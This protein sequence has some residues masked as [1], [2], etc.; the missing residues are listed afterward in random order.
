MAD[1]TTTLRVMQFN[2]EFGGHGVDFS[3]VSK[4]ILACGADVVAIQ[5]GCA[6][7]PEIAA[8]LGWDYWD[9]RTQ[10]VSNHPLLTPEVVAPGTILVEVE[11]GLVFGVVN[12]H[13]PSRGYGPTR[14]GKGAPTAKVLQR[15]SRVRLPSVEAAL[16][17][18]ETLTKQGI[19]VVL[20]GDF[21]APS[22]RDWTAETVGL[23]THVISPMSWPT[24]RA[25]ESAGLT[26][27]YRAIYPDPVARQGLTW[28][29]DRPFV[30]G[31]NP[32]AAGKSADRIDLM[33]V[34]DGVRPLSIEIVGEARSEFTD[35]SI[36]PWPTDHRALV[37]ELKISLGHAP[38]LVSVDRRRGEVG[39]SRIVRYVS[40]HEEAASVE[41]RI[42]KAGTF[43][44]V[45]SLRLESGNTGVVPW[46][47]DRLVPGTYDLVLVDQENRELARATFWLVAPGES[48]RVATDKPVYSV[49]EAIEASWTNGPG[50]KSDWI[51]IFDRGASPENSK[52]RVWEYID[53]QVEGRFR[54]DAQVRPRRWP[55]PAGEY[56]VYLMQDDSSIKLSQADFTV[57]SIQR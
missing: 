8:D 35:I 3:S 37:A 29:A 14:L 15:E 38:T 5:E 22:H 30:K 24:S 21:N 56:S 25:V 53:A 13:P 23:R 12:V 16:R 33:Y 52:A 51:A 19:P 50:N 18:A 48:P 9:A 47:T 34:S 41:V 43:D 39:H 7:M 6:T 2:I 32:G 17:S 40:Q 11:A 42:A 20:L 55:V 44:S 54:F 49:S 27:V 1:A 45:S 46:S 31:Y 36:D 10:V 26:D 4:A 28:P 57:D